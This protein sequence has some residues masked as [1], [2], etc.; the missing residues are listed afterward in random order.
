MSAS[1][2]FLASWPSSYFMENSIASIRLKYLLST[3]LSKLASSFGSIPK[4][5]ESSSIGGPNISTCFNPSSRQISCTSLR[6]SFFAMVKAI[7]APFS[8]ASIKMLFIFPGFSIFE[9]T[10]SADDGRSN[11]IMLAFNIFIAL[12]PI[13]SEMIYTSFSSWLPCFVI[14][15]TDQF[16]LRLHSLKI[17]YSDNIYT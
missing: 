4:Y 8:F 15:F 14:K 10:R 9:N 1:K 2:T 16:V 6:V 7:N 13:P 17:T 11:W 12:W 3:L 5:A